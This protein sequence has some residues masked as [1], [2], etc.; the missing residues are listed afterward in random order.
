MITTF[1]STHDVFIDQVPPE[2]ILEANG[3]RYPKGIGK[4]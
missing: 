2:N 3:T 4:P 1:L